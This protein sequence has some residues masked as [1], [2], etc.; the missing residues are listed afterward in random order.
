MT[1]TQINNH[2]QAG[3]I[4]TICPWDSAWSNQASAT[5]LSVSEGH[6]VYYQVDGCEAKIS[7]P[8]SFGTWRTIVESLKNETTY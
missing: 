1:V 7:R 2:I 8:V 3:A 6:V 5:V 4:I